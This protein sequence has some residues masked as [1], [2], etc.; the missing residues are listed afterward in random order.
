MKKGLL[1]AIVVLWI[2]WVI[3]AAIVVP[4]LYIVGQL[5]VGTV[6]GAWIYFVR[7][8]WKKGTS[9]FH[10]EMKPE[11]AER[12]LKRL[13]TFLLVAGISLAVSIVGF[14]VY[15]VLWEYYRID[16]SVSFAM[17]LFGIMA[18]LIATIGGLVIFLKGRRKTTKEMPK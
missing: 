17:G 11:L 7:M 15:I 5:V 6:M 18:F 3:A 12:R 9:L 2:G 4:G 14:A 13:K 1:I 16:D 8:V 10:E